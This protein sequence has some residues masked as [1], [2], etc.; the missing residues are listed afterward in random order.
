MLAAGSSTRMKR[1][2]PK[3]LLHMPDG[4]SILAHALAN[5]LALGPLGIIVVVRPDLPA[6]LESLD[7]LPVTSVSNPHYAEGMGTSLAAGVAALPDDAQAVL[8]LLGDEPDVSPD[9]VHR[10]VES[11]LSSKAAIT[12]PTYGE[13]VGPPTLFSRDRFL[14]L[15]TLQGDTGGRQL[16]ELYPD[17]VCRVP[18][19][20][21]ER[22]KD[23]DTPEDLASMQA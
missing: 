8:V 6:L 10:L 12:V 20:H 23:I 5:A 17:R 9:I 22:P 16:F 2:L 3:L 7:G 15:A 19:T 4:R 1:G 18:F 14:D 13:Q 21:D 11:Y